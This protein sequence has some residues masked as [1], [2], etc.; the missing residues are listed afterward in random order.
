MNI[1][2]APTFVL[3]RLQMATYLIADEVGRKRSLGID[4]I[5]NSFLMREPVC[6]VALINKMYQLAHKGST[7][8]KTPGGSFC[9][10]FQYVCTLIIDCLVSR[11][12]L[13]NICAGF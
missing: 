2:N 5:V 6:T 12:L 10:S 13:I 4:E 7:F 11:G 3:F 9:D 1:L 8:M